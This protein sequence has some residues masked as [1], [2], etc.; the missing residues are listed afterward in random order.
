[1]SRHLH[2]LARTYTKTALLIGLLLAA[3]QAGAV[4][5]KGSTLLGLCESDLGQA[6]DICGGYIAS[7]YDAHNAFVAWNDPSKRQ[8]CIGS[9]TTIGELRRV[10]IKYMQAHPENLHQTASSLVANAFIQ[11]FPCE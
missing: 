10:V 5:Y 1:M 3:S 2:V 7:I 4:F 11:A 8:W 9:A 6:G